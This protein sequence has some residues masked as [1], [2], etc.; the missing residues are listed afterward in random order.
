MTAPGWLYPVLTA[1]FLVL[2]YRTVRTSGA[3]L[4][5]AVAFM[6]V[7]NAGL[8]W[9]LWETGPP[10]SVPVVAAV[11]LVA[12]VVNLRA[13]ALALMARIERIDLAGF[14]S[15]VETVAQAP[16]PQVMGVC[17]LH[18]GTVALTAFG[19]DARPEGRQFHLPPG[20]HCPLCLVEDQMRDFLV[21]PEPLLR[22]YRAHLRAGSSRHLL[23]KRRSPEDPWTGR[24]RDRAFYRVPEVRPPCPVHD[25]LFTP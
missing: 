8:L 17:A 19:D 24:L 25:P 5:V 7:L 11:S 1:A 9:L 20:A 4:R 18:T 3:G 14:R 12:A 22:E 13:A 2:A 6:A 16:G 23:I 15:L 10:W 21:E